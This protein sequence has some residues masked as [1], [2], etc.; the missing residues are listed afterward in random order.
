ML[1][2]KQRET[3]TIKQLTRTLV[4]YILLPRKPEGLSTVERCWG[5]ESKLPSDRF[6]TMWGVS[7]SHWGAPHLHFWDTEKTHEI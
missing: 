6:K 2:L 5:Q 3:Y 1:N 7:L 4:Y